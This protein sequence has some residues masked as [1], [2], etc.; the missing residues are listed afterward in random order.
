VRLTVLQG[1]DIKTVVVQPR[2][3]MQTLR[4]PAGI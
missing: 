2:D 1:A 4:K 3:R